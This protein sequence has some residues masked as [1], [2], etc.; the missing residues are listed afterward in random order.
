MNILVTV[1][2]SSASQKILQYV[3]TLALSLSA[4]VWLLYAAKPPIRGHNTY[5]NCKFSILQSS[6]DQHTLKR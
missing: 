6:R 3:K 4:K 1:D 2:L 5:F